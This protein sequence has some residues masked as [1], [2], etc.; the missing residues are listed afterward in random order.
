MACSP[1]SNPRVTPSQR[2]RKMWSRLLSNAWRAGGVALALLAVSGCA[3]PPATKKPLP[4]VNISAPASADAV[5]ALPAI[6]EQPPPRALADFDRAV[7]LMRAGNQAQA[8]LEFQALSVGYPTFA[9]P[10][11][12]L[13]I[14]Y[15]KEGRLE[16]SEA[17]L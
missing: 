13:G 15:R 6:A 10:N 17:A 2:S 8:E 12:N 11:I 14:L 5:A 1:S 4:A 9:G 16:Q 7:G 3:S